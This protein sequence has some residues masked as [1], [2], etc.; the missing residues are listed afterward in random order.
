MTTWTAASEHVHDDCERLDEAFCTGFASPDAGSRG[1]NG[2]CCRRRRRRRRREEFFPSSRA[3]IFRPSPV[4]RLALLVKYLDFA[5]QDAGSILA[6]VMIPPM[7]SFQMRVADR[8]L[9]PGGRFPADCMVAEEG[10]RIPPRRRQCLI[11]S[12]W[13]LASRIIPRGGA[14]L[15]DEAR[16]PY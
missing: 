5:H 9:I 15:G 12:R 14:W 1:S 6:G 7:G 13:S 2:Q 11:W 4:A 3:P 8:R 16:F 10:S